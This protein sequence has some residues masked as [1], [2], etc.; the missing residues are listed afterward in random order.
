M[1]FT[2]YQLNSNKT[3]LNT[4]ICGNKFLYPVLGLSNESGEFLGKIKKIFR[5]KNGEIDLETKKDLE[6]ELGDVLWYLSEICTQL[7]LSLDDVAFNNLQKL[8]SRQTRGVLQGNG[9]NR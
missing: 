2:F 6:S 4:N 8:K 1:D 7:D 9:D 3:S 5:D